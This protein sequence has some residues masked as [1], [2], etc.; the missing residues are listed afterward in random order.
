MDDKDN[1]SLSFVINPENLSGR[2]H[3]NKIRL[4]ISARVIYQPIEWD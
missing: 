1:L 3:F 2:V 4:S